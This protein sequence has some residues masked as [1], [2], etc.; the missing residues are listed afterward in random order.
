MRK[1]SGLIRQITILILI[2]MIIISVLTYFTQLQ[3]ATTSVRRMKVSAGM[4][5]NQNRGSTA[6]REINRNGV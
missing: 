5:M 6:L 2:G 3:L 4:I 1:K